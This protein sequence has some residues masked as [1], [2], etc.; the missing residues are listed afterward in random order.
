MTRTARLQLLPWLALAMAGCATQK[1]ANPSS[2]SVP[3]EQYQAL[4]AEHEATEAEVD[5]LQLDLARQRQRGDR[6]ERDAERLRA[7]IE[8]AEETLVSLESGLKGMH[9]RADAVSA[10]ADARILV[11]RAAE[12]AP[13]RRQSIERAREKLAEAERHI[14]ENYFGSAVFFT[15]RGRRLAE[16]V[17]AQARALRADGATWFVRPDRANVRGEPSM[18]ARIVVILR[19]GTPVTVQGREDGWAQIVTP[20]ESGG[21]IYG[22]LL[23]RKP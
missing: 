15:A 17:L 3:L 19:A 6:L 12:Q 21:W 2:D 5:R 23:T 13:W 11:G 1:A 4:Q 20:D 7:D 18:N 9:S 10:L 22:Q 8:D 16:E 14:E